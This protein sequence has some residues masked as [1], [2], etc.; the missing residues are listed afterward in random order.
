M[1]RDRQIVG[2]SLPPQ[3]AQAFKEEAKRRNLSVRALFE[4]LWAT[5]SPP[6]AK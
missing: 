5:Y 2:I 4:E 1:V 6:A 3:T